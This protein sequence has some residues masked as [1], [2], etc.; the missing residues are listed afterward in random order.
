MKSNHIFKEI[1]STEYLRKL[2]RDK[3]E[4]KASPGIDK[5]NKETFNKRFDQE[6]NIIIKKTYANTYNFSYYLERLISKGRDKKPRV[7]SISTIRDKIT[8]K[9]ITEFLSNT[10]E[11]A[12]SRELVHTKIY[13]IKNDILSG[14]YDTFIKIDIQNFFPSINHDKLLKIIKHKIHV[15]LFIDLLSKAIKQTTVTKPS[16]STK[17]YSEE[18]GVPQGLSISNILADIFMQ[19]IDKK[20][21]AKSKIR[22]YRYVDDIL[23][24]CNQSQEKVLF[25]NIKRDFEK[26]DLNIHGLEKNSNKT[27]YGL[28]AEGFNFLGY[29]YENSKLTVRTASI[30]K[31]E[32]SIVK[33][34]AQYKY[35]DQK[36]I[37]WLEWV[38]NLKITGCRIDE[39]KYGWLFFFSQINDINLLFRLDKFVESMYI[40]FGIDKEYKVKKFVRAYHEILNN[41]TETKYIPN[42]DLFDFEDKRILLM[43]V[44]SLPINGWDEVKIEIAFKRKIYKSIK[45]LEKDIQW[46]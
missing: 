1:F 39:K 27:D 14:Q 40:K 41:R 9:A 29:L 12:V 26:K 30:E 23:I 43:D 22:Y 8:L 19:D 24:L 42:F 11:E 32:N 33:I 2:Y 6:I 15:K 37:K 38:L 17:K 36:N 20:Y 16:S 31:L 44:F 45:E 25:Q 34:F 46:Y 4:F 10:Y 3:I 13:N 18:K 5:I 35:S 21:K 7:L 28:I